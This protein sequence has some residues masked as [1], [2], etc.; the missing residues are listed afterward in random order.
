[1][2]GDSITYEEGSCSSIV[3]HC[4]RYGKDTA[5][6]GIKAL[7]C[8][9]CFLF[10]LSRQLRHMEERTHP[11]TERLKGIHCLFISR[12]VLAHI[13]VSRRRGKWIKL[14]SDRTRTGLLPITLHVP[15]L[16]IQLEV[17]ILEILHL[18]T[19]VR[20]DLELLAQFLW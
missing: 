13:V 4:F 16:L 18:R 5:L 10:R 11:S 7:I 6:D 12:P 14:T 2:Q 1:M 8:P 3:E 17:V 15:D 9:C 20:D 19:Q